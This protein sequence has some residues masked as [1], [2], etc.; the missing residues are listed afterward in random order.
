MSFHS[1]A[2]SRAKPA[3]P[4]KAEASTATVADL[5]TQV[6]RQHMII[7]ALCHLLIA[8]GVM[9]EKELNEWASYVDKLDGREDGQL[10]EIRQPRTCSSCKR[11]SAPTATACQYCG[12]T[13]QTSVLVSEG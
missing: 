2:Q 10:R 13:L 12:K 3:F 9:D 7:Q 6:Y 11:V 1:H 4:P 8:K 5:Q